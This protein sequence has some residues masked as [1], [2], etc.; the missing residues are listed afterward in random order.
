MA[1]D[2]LTPSKAAPRGPDP[3]VGVYYKLAFF[4]V[5]LFAAPLSA[6]YL[7][8]ERLFEGNVTYA[9]GL[10]ALV[11]NVVLVA[12]IVAAFLEDQGDAPAAAT[13]SAAAGGQPRRLETKAAAAAETKKEQ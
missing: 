1:S 2:Q 3:A 5:A 12:Y 10:A 11:A 7:S 8:R 6:F 4:S 13:A 9:G